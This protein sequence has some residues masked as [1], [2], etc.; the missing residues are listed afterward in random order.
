[1]NNFYCV[2]KFDENNNI[3]SFKDYIDFNKI[4]HNSYD[5]IDDEY[6]YMFN[7]RKR[8]KSNYVITDC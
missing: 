2:L 6:K 5:E 4:K 7:E 1:M 8:I 3:T